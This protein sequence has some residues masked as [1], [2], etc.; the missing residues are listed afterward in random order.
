MKVVGTE[1]RVLVVDDITVKVFS[2]ACKLSDVTEESVSR[3]PPRPG[4]A[5][6]R[7]GP[8]VTPGTRSFWLFSSRRADAPWQLWRTSPSRGSP[9]RT[10][11]VRR[12]GF[13]G[14]GVF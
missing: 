8:R 11:Q 10:S 5:A 2:S 13:A 1:W 6:G 9:C 12:A 3:A 7:H 14:R 4:P